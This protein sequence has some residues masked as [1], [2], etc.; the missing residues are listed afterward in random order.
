ML[1]EP[2]FL[3]PVDERAGQ[4]DAVLA[5][6]F[7]ERGHQGPLALHGLGRAD[8]VLAELRAELDGLLDGSA[9]VEGRPG[10]GRRALPGLRAVRAGGEKDAQ[11]ASARG[12]FSEVDPRHGRLEQ[13]RGGGGLED[14]AGDRTAGGGGEPGRGRHLLAGQGDAAGNGQRGR[15]GGGPGQDQPAFG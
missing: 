2:D 9:E 5:E 15:V 1:V 7:Q 14:Q 11:A 10:T 13:P 3:Q 12:E 8:G 4:L 6:C